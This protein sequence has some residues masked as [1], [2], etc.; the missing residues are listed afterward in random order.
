MKVT[1]C[2]CPYC[3]QYRSVLLGSFLFVNGFA[4]LGSI[5]ALKMILGTMSND[6]YMQ[7]A[8]I[9]LNGSVGE[10]CHFDCRVLLWI[11]ETKV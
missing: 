6:I 9:M 10:E 8:L 5:P 1:F 2:R 11:A 4:A 7:I 3:F